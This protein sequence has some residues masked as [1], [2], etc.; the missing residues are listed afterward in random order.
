MRKDDLKF[1]QK[2][3]RKG[4]ILGGKMLECIEMLQSSRR[5]NNAGLP[6]ILR[7]KG[8]LTSEQVQEIERELSETAEKNSD[9]QSSSLP[10]I[11]AYELLQKMGEGGMGSVY[12][13]KHASNGRIVA[14]KLLDAE[15]SKD[16]EFITRFLREARNVAKLKRH[17]NIV[18]AYDF[19]ESNGRYY[20]AMEFVD[21]RSLAEILYGHGKVDE[22]TALH[23]AK[24]VARALCHANSFSIVHRDVKPENIMISKEGVVK[25]CD[26]GLAKDL[27]E[28]FHKWGGVTLGTVYYASPEQV[29]GF[30]ELVDIRSDIYSLGI[31]LYHMLCGEAPFN[32]SNIRDVARRHIHEELPPLEQKNSD[33][34]KETLRLVKKMTVKSLTDRYQKPEDVVEEIEHILQGKNTPQ[35]IFVVKD[36]LAPVKEPTPPAP[37]F[38]KR[39]FAPDVP[40][41]VYV[42][43]VGLV[44]LAMAGVIALLV[45]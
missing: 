29:S 19:G 17:E 5:P 20:F 2:A 42:S 26:L 40:W 16:Q 9:A 28:N 39:N 36:K 37:L 38:K 41:Y 8:Y 22:R 32:D 34:S 21:G 23:V 6:E 7:L 35:P 12:K 27:S 10:K 15:L 44:L 24:Q 1:A 18:E 11:A 30:R 14:L 25:L 31:S 45:S 13:A 4:W 43:F 33:L 3:V